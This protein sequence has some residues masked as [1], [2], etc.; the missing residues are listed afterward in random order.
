MTQRERQVAVALR[1]GRTRNEIAHELGISPNTVGTI[2][3]K[4]YAK[5]GVHRRAELVTRLAGLVAG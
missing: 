2:T 3:R 4:V 5:L 1:D